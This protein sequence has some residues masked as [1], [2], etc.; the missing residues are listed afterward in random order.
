MARSLD[1]IQLYRISVFNK[2]HEIVF[3]GKGYDYT[4]VYNMPIWLRNFTFKKCKAWYEAEAEQ[5]TNNTNDIDL[6]NPDK[7]KLPPKT[8]Q[9]PNYVTKASKK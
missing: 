5:T 9:P 3:H 7:S 2:I 4:T 8:I 1:Q 6:S